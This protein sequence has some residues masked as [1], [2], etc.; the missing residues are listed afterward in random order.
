MNPNRLTTEE[1]ERLWY[2][3]GWPA[4]QRPADL[5][6]ALECQ[7]WRDVV[8]THDI[9]DPAAL[10]QHLRETKHCHAMREVLH[11]LAD[12]LDGVPQ[13]LVIL[14]FLALPDADVMERV[15]QRIDRPG[16]CPMT[17]A[18]MDGTAVDLWING[19]RHANCRFFVDSW[20]SASGIVSNPTHWMAIPSGPA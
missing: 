15:L 10:D 11:A 6:D 18:P 5:D 9:A 3:L 16:W 12:H 7:Q 20:W 14:E 2:C 19:A 1:A 17:T 4:P 13:G 8:Q